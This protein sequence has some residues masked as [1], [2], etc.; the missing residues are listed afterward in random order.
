MWFLSYEDWEATG[1]FTQRKGVGQVGLLFGK[2]T[3]AHEEQFG[4]EKVSR[5]EG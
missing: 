2:L 1:G 4:K 5:R 3:L